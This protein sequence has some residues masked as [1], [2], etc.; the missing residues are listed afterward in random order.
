MEPMSYA[1]QTLW[2]EKTRYAAGVGAV[3]FSDVLIV[4]Q[5]GLLLGLF[6]MTSIP[7]DHT[8][9]HIWVG[10]Q[11]VKS[12]DLGIG[13][14]T[15][16]NLSR[17]TAK[18]GLVGQPEIF[19]AN[20]ANMIRPD[21]GMERCY[22]LGGSLDPNAA[23]A[24][25]VLTPELRTALTMP[26]SIVVDESD[27]KRVNLKHVGETA[28]INGVPVILV[29]TVRG[30]KSLAAPWVLCSVTTARNVLANF[31]LP[32]HTSYLLARTESP[33]RAKQIVA[34]LRAE[35]PEMSV[36]TADDFSFSSR[37]YWLTRTKAGV[38]IGYAALLGLMVGA[39]ITAQTL[40]SATMA[41]AKEF[42]TLLALGIPRK[43]IYWMVL[44]QSFWVGVIGVVVSLPVVW[45]LA[46]A[47]AAGGA[48]VIL[49][50]EVLSGAAIVTISTALLSGL[51]ALRS[52]RRIQPMDLLR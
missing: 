2:H 23:G 6:T 29:G 1:L 49:R 12:V 50:W 15:N 4:L 24:V 37:W 3:A 30:L 36:Y 26:N 5:V 20:F 25:D 48:Q 52:V 38:A 10:S 22:V 39:V 34:E 31:V 7:V 21:G 33:L 16:L 17:L 11:D 43:R 32:D 18:P 44:A 14:P 40:Y 51:Y 46:Q 35:Y 19:L 47:A 42:A 13:I 28:K 45:L 27:L 41:S 8:R 9:A